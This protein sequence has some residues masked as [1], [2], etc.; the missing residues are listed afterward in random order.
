M[1][2]LVGDRPFFQ[3]YPQRLEAVFKRQTGHVA[4]V[5]TPEQSRRG[6]LEARHRGI[7]EQLGD[8]LRRQILGG[9][10]FELVGDH[11][12]EGGVGNLPGRVDSGVAQLV[13]MTEQG[14]MCLLL[15]KIEILGQEQPPGLAVERGHADDHDDQ[16]VPP[17]L[18]HP[19][20]PVAEGGQFLGL[21]LVR[22]AAS[23]DWLKRSW[24]R[25]RKA[26]GINSP[27]A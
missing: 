11:V 20:P 4:V 26:C 16:L 10:S 25:V 14:P 7:V 6:T 9:K 8:P 12:V 2:N 27:H 5:A 1:C 22:H 13:E 19:P 17:V 3:E 23:L 24:A 18:E 15:I 21:Q